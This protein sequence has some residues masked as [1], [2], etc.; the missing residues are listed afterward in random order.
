MNNI[1]VVAFQGKAPT[2]KEIEAI[3]SIINGDVEVVRVIDKNSIADIVAKHVASEVKL[4]VEDEPLKNAATFINAHFDSPWKLIGA[5]GSARSS[6]FHSEDETALINAVDII[7][8]NSADKCAEY[9]IPA[10]IHNAC[11]NIKYHILNME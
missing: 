9:G 4:C 8:N 3:A 10:I 11:Y 2:K 7:A 6:A 5:I 1:L